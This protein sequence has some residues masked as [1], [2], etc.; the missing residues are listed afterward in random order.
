MQLTPNLQTKV[1]EPVNTPLAPLGNNETENQ[2]A[3]LVDAFNLAAVNR[4]ASCYDFR[5]KTSGDH[6]I[7]VGNIRR[8]VAYPVV[9]PRSRVFPRRKAVMYVVMSSPSR[10]TIYWPTADGK[11]YVRGS[12]VL[13]SGDLVMVS[14]NLHKFVLD[15]VG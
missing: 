7:S 8:V 2:L 9:S 3:L 14:G 11:G 4:S 1:P 13:L 10:S 6:R 5:G 12:C 15:L